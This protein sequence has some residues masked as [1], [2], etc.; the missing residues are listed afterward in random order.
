MGEGINVLSVWNGGNLGAGITVAVVDDGMHHQHEDLDDN[1]D[2]SK[3]HDYTG[4]NEIYSPFETHGTAVAAGLISADDNGIGMRGVAPDVT[5]YGY[6]YLVEQS[7]ANEA[8][9]MSRNAATTAISNNSWGPGGSAGPE[10]ATSLWEG[11]VEAGV[12]DGYSGKGVLYVWSG[13]NGARLGDDSNLDEYNNFYAVTSVCAVNYS[14]TRTVY[15][16][17]GTNLWVC[18]PSDDSGAPGIA[19]TDNGNRYQ[20]S[21]GGTSAAAPIVSGVAALIREAN[22]ALTWRDVKLILA[23]SARKN[24]TINGG[25][26]EGAFKY[27][28]TTDRYNFNHEYGFGMVDAAAAVDLADGWTNVPPLRKSTDTS[29]NTNLSIPDATSTD[30]GVTVVPGETKTSELTLDASVEFVEYIHVDTHFSHSSFRDLDVVLES[31]SGEKS[32]LVPHF[33]YEAFGPAI[34]TIGLTDPFR[35]GSAKHLGEDAAGTWKLHITDHLLADTG[36][37]RSWSIT[38]FGHGITPLAPDI[39]EVFPASGGFTATWKAPADTG[40][41]DISAYDVRYILSDA[42]DK[43]DG[44]WMSRTAG[45]SALQYTASGLAAGEQYDVQVRAVNSGGDGPWSAT[46]TV[47]PTTADAPTVESIT[48]GNGTLAVAWIVP[49]NTGLGTIDS[50]DLRYGRG[51]SPSSWTVVD[52]A[53]TSGNLE[54]TI[55]PTPALT[56]GVTYG[57][58]VRAVVGT[59][60]HPWSETRSATPRTVPGAPTI[61]FVDGDDGKLIVEWSRAIR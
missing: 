44:K 19:T 26:E 28:S 54:Y 32:T 59:T 30:M 40:R 43:S 21:F 10:P 6:N 36:R 12:T 33:D 27:G 15:S 53:W 14:D 18:A 29:G 51:N 22:N 20:D 23:A 9:A 48:P 25:W 50:Y 37:L 61:D 38:A 13:G 8:N 49:G 3:N 34:P 60:E 31:P 1:V 24:D 52:D 46:S 45:S 11:A 55:N 56:N 2:T 39:E 4:G 35:F 57:V 16:E 7:M 5:I 17:P 41:S 47:T 58:Q 42:T